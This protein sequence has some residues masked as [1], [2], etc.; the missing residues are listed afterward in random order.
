MILHLCMLKETSKFAAEITA[1]GIS[2]GQEIG[3]M[4]QAL[5]NGVV[6][7]I[8]ART[9]G[10]EPG[11]GMFPMTARSALIINRNQA[12]PAGDSRVS[13]KI[14]FEQHRVTATY[15]IFNC[16]TSS[17]GSSGALPDLTASHFQA[18]WWLLGNPQKKSVIM[19]WLCSNPLDSV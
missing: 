5:S 10:A 7:R 16:S 1:R 6:V 18:F 8:I 17:I 2:C 13:T 11:L 4:F 3:D 15:S 19:T 12:L 9:S 14:R